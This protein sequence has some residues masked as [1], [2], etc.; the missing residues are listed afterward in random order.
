LGKTNSKNF[1]TTS[2]RRVTTSSRRVTSCSRRVISCNRRV[3]TSSR[4]V[5]SCSTRIISCREINTYNRIISCRGPTI[6]TIRTVSP[7]ISTSISITA[8]NI[9]I[10]SHNSQSIKSRR[11]QKLKIEMK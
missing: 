1:R 8:C 2:S 7:T 5:T 6:N 4:R 9:R 11:K 10:A 3:T